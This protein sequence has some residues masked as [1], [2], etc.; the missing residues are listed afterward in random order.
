MA[1]E[2]VDTAQARSG[3]QRG[4]FVCKNRCAAE[5]GLLAAKAALGRG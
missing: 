1:Q 4:R 2:E 3:S 5:Q